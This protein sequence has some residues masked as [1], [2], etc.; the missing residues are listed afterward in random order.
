MTTVDLYVP[1]VG[2]LSSD[3][4]SNIVMWWRQWFNSM[5]KCKGNFSERVAFSF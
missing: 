1:M 3:M 4:I 2:S 5:V